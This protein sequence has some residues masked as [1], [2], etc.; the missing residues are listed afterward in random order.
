V[1][2]SRSIPKPAWAGPIDRRLAISQNGEVSLRRLIAAAIVLLMLLPSAA[3]LAV[4]AHLAL[5]HEADHHPAAGHAAMLEVAEH[6]HSHDDGD[7][8]HEHPAAGQE[9]GAARRAAAPL[10]PAADP[11]SAAGGGELSAFLAPGLR[12]VQ[13]LAGL[14][15][16]C[17]PP[18]LALL[19]ILRI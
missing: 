12:S 17:G 15:A 18:L 4:A 10:P 3:A 13:G 8:V 11:G 2:N 14:P 6:G 7:P 1:P 16:I 9:D 19:S 5:D